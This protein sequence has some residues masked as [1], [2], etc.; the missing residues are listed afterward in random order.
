MDWIISVG[1]RATGTFLTGFVGLLGADQ[2]W[3]ID[4]AGGFVGAETVVNAVQV[5][6][7]AAVSLVILP[8]ISRIG[9]ALKSTPKGKL[10]SF[11]QDE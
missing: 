6:A 10:P 4:E 1:K 2:M 8:A 5:G 3:N 11:V 7:A 9:N